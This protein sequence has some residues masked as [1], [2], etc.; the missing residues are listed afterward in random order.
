[1]DEKIKPS[2]LLQKDLF[3]E[4]EFCDSSQIISK[5][6]EIEELNDFLFNIP[7]IDNKQ[8][9]CSLTHAKRLGLNI[10]PF[11]CSSWMPKCLDYCLSAKTGQFQTLGYVKKYS[12]FLSY[13]FF[14]RPD[15][16]DKT[17]SGNVYYSYRDL[18]SELSWIKRQNISD[19]LM[20]YLNFEPKILE[21]EYRLVYID[22][23]FVDGCL[24]M[25]RGEKNVKK[26]LP[27]NVKKFANSIVFEQSKDLF[28]NVPNL[29][30]D[31]AEF[32]DYDTPKLGLIEFNMFE[33][34]S[35][36]A[37]DL[38]KIYKKWSDSIDAFSI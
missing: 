6:F 32:H 25:S 36:Y 3:Y 5:Y 26:V 28:L 33:T 23:E 16:G 27:E 1:M 7:S 24:Y 31:I 4:D 38:D 19:S 37:C 21:N 18:E 34:A 8:V 15:S 35:F 20:C 9:R 2:I 29:V 12:E 11:F 10:K 13:P 17:F 30:I 14:L 22:H